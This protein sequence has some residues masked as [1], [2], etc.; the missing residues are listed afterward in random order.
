MRW[1]PPFLRALLLPAT[2]VA[3][4]PA[5]LGQGVDRDALLDRVLREGDEVPRQVLRQIAEPADA[6]ALDD[7]IEATEELRAPATLEVAYQSFSRF[8]ADAELAGEA[9]AFLVDEVGRRKPGLARRAV[10][11]LVR[12]M[13]HA[14]A[15][16]HEIVRDSS[17]EEHR[18]VAI[19][20]LL[21]EIRTT[22]TAEGLDWLLES[23][24]L[25]LSGKAG[26]FLKTLAAFPLADCADEF[27]DRLKD[28]DYPVDLRLLILEALHGAEDE[29]AVALGRLA[30]RDEEPRVVRAAVRLLTAL[31]VE[32]TASDLKKLS[33]ADDPGLRLEGLL[34]QARQGRGRPSVEE[35]VHDWA[36]SRDPVRRQA[37]ALSLAVRPAPESVTT[38]TTLLNDEQLPVRLDA[39]RALI[40]LRRTDALEVLMTHAEHPDRITARVI[41]R[42][43]TALTEQEFGPS[44]RTWE[45]WWA[46]H[47][48]EFA[49]PTVKR[50]RAR[51]EDQ[52][53]DG[54]RAD[55]RTG[56]SFWGLPI[57]SRH[58]VFVLD[59]SNSMESRFA[60][61]TR[62]GA[63]EQTRLAAAKAQLI[64]ALERLPDGAR[65]SIVLFDVRAD[66]WSEELV[67]LD[68]DSRADATQWVRDCDTGGQTNVHDA[69]RRAFD[70]EGITTIY[71]LS[72]GVPYGGAI[73]DPLLL[74]DAVQGWNAT[75]RIP[76][77]A[78]SL[79]GRVDLLRQLAAD[80]GG[81]FRH[82]R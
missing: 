13:P 66:P 64:G 68:E 46:D 17:H 49:M 23:F 73:D 34:V 12:L 51:W 21:D 22:P 55:D 37:A 63:R 3:F 59:T 24:R 45:R 67:E 80:S 11:G 58:V 42:G 20:G 33:R 26:D 60:Q 82:V 4:A 65:F 61:A 19:R 10:G 40:G 14:R 7:L 44:R 81:E 30:L 79:G 72:D 31:E 76:I 16:L 36:D 50:L 69:L 71:L 77:H 53:T 27:E 38:L 57:L 41:H 74:R 35:E 29:E 25:R 70:F 56:A 5:V 75:R 62:Y 78:I 2:V 54:P 47:R 18:A 48:A 32:W 15:A 1:L 43:L 8:G 6:R 39:A 28:D 52:A 9:V